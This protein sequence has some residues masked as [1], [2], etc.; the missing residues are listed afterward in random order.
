M[1]ESTHV[2]V[3]VPKAVVV[4]TR[5]RVMPLPLEADALV[6][7]LAPHARVIDCFWRFLWLLALLQLGPSLHIARVVGHPLGQVIGSSRLRPRMPKLISRRIR[8]GD[9]RSSPATSASEVFDLAP[10]PVVSAPN[11][12]AIFVGQLSGRAQMVAVVVQDAAG[13]GAGFLARV[14]KLL[15]F[16]AQPSQMLVDLSR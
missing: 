15:G 9:V 13:F 11:Q 7:R 2:W 14:L 1:N 16:A 10:S 5:L 12:L 8:T 4:Q 6:G 3:V